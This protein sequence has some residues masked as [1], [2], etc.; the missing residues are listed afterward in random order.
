M[1]HQAPGNQLGKEDGPAPIKGEDPL[2]LEEYE[3]DSSGE[4]GE[5]N[6][7]EGLWG[8]PVCRFLLLLLVVFCF[9][10]GTIFISVTEFLH[11]FEKLPL[12]VKGLPSKADQFSSLPLDFDSFKNLKKGNW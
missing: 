1:I 12:V 7:S 8:Y 6:E 11:W 5:P 3:R 9:C 2:I 4:R 10:P